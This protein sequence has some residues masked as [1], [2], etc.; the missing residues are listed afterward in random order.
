MELCSYL[1][2]RENKTIF[3]RTFS[4]FKTYCEQILDRW[5]V[6]LSVWHVLFF[7]NYFFDCVRDDFIRR[8]FDIRFLIAFPP[9]VYY[10]DDG[11]GFVFGCFAWLSVVSHSYG[12]NFAPCGVL[13]D[14]LLCR[15]G[16]IV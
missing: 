14:L 4:F 3:T 9:F 6:C 1:R 12:V 8:L 15:K 7:K 5:C 16:E 2:Y 13:V 11:R 10:R